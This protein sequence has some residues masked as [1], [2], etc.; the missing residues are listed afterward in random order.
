MQATKIRHTFN[1]LATDAVLDVF[2]GIAKLLTGIPMP[3]F[4]LEFPPL[5]EVTIGSLPLVHG[6][7][8]ITAELVICCCSPAF[9]PVPLNFYVS[10]TNS[11]FLYQGLKYP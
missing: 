9:H 6:R 11:V 1:L 7:Q 10:Y 2:V 5:L 8:G 4:W 3:Y